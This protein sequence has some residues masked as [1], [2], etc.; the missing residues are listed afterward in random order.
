MTRRLRRAGAAALVAALAVTTL[1]P[2]GSP[3]RR[4]V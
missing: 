2:R 3:R 1:A 4:A